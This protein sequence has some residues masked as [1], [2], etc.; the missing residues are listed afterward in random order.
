MHVARFCVFFSRSLEVLQ[1]MFRSSSARRMMAGL[2]S[3]GSFRNAAEVYEEGR[4]YSD[5]AQAWEAADDAARAIRCWEQDGSY[6]EAVRLYCQ[7]PLRSV[8]KGAADRYA[9]KWRTVRFAGALYRHLGDL[10]GEI[11]LYIAWKAW[12]EAAQALEHIGSRVLLSIQPVSQQLP[13]SRGPSPNCEIWHLVCLPEDHLPK[14]SFA[15]SLTI[16]VLRNPNNG[17]QRWF[18]EKLWLI[19]HI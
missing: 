3:L 13:C 6:A 19:V 14:N 15:R 11:R 10:E 16:K 1:V 2:T 17:E 8:V 5:A 9:Q 4:Q 12:K 18:P 7:L